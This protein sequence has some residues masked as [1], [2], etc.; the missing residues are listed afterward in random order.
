MRAGRTPDTFRTAI[1]NEQRNRAAV[2]EG[3]MPV[4]ARSSMTTLSS[5][6]VPVDGSPPSLAALAHAVVLAEDYDAQIVVLHVIPDEDPLSPAARNEVERAM[7]SGVEIAREVLGKRLV[8]RTTIG[9]PLRE[10]VAGAREGADLIVMGTHGWV[11]RIHEMLGS[12][13]EGVVRNAP[14]PVLTVR[15]SGSGYQSFAERRHGRPS[16]A[17]QGAPIRGH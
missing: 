3:G 17:E 12:V 13:A 16:L 4:A 6:L 5:I 8:R 9:D 11:G 7:D 14:C 2:S 10:I 15:D 1:T